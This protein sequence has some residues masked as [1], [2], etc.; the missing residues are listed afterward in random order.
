MAKPITAILAVILVMMVSFPALSE[1]RTM[2]TNQTLSAKQ[3]SII[4]IAAFTANGDME[5][6]K[7]ALN[8]GLDAGL[9]VNEIKEILV[10]M[11]AYAGFPRSL[12]GIH[13]FMAVMDER[14]ANGIEDERGQEV[15]P[16]PV[17]LNKDEY[18]ARV[19]AMLAGQEVIPPPSGYQLFT[20]IIDTFLKEHLFAYI[21]ARDTLD[22]QSR[23]LATIAALASMTGISGQLRFHLGA[24]MNTGL[25]EAQLKDFISVL[26]AKVGKEE[27]QSASE[28][29]AEVSS[30]STN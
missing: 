4:P 21:F 25:T 18:G 7:T 23:E 9:T 5:K 13:A 24:A 29:L 1:T 10:Q 16:V 28:L 11:Y 22:Y 2:D 15:S 20:P 30:D 12:N 6:L 14:Q 8:E 17:D 27:A 19:R 3:Q 26:Q